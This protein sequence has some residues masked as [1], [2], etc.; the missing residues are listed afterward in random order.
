[1]S[2]QKQIRRPKAQEQHWRAGVLYLRNASRAN[3]YWTPDPEHSPVLRVLHGGEAIDFVP[4]IKFSHWVIVRLEHQLG[5][6][7][8]ETVEIIEDPLPAVNPAQFLNAFD[9]N[10]TEPVSRRS[11]RKEDIEETMIA[12]PK[13]LDQRIRDNMERE[14]TDTPADQPADTTDNGINTGD[15]RRLIRF[16]TGKLS[17]TRNRHK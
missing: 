8:L 15:L 4:E 16:V 2:P 6:V 9:E 13:A 3:L 17:G 11:A 10:E 5:W 7:T 1:M 12:R 14:E